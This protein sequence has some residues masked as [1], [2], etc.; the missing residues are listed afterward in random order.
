MKKAGKYEIQNSFEGQFEP[1][2]RNRVLKN[3]IGIKRKRQM[4][5]V[6]FSKYEETFQHALGYYSANHSFTANDIC[7]LHHFWLKDIY[8]WAGNYRSVNMAKDGFEFAAAMRI[9]KLMKDF[10]AKFL[11]VYTP[12]VS[13]SYEKTIEAI[14]IVH[15]ELILVHPFRD[16]NGRLSRLLATLMALQNNLPVLDYDY[17]KGKRRQEYFNAINFGLQGD[18]SFMINIFNNVVNRSLKRTYR[19]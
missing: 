14:A 10:E 13:L 19:N 2:S 11:K 15:V 5:Q 12:C 7:Y 8:P 4:D 9:P 17:I 16:G 1:G 18:Y 6:E 3:L